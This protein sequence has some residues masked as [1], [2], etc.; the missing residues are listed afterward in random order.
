MLAETS[1]SE[2][3]GVK[4]PKT[5]IE[6]AAT[7]VTA[8]VPPEAPPTCEYTDEAEPAQTSVD[9]EI[10]VGQQ[11]STNPPASSIYK[12]EIAPPFPSTTRK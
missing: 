10:T 4:L 5:S 1:D 11:I 3:L 6:P 9:P 7:G 12:G 8:Q 2:L